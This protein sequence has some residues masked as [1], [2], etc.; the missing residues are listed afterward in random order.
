MEHGSK[1]IVLELAMEA[2]AQYHN[3]MFW[4]DPYLTRKQ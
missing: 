4:L 3:V 1:Y 2:S